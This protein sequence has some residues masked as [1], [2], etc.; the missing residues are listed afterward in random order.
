MQD[1][2]LHSQS[3]LTPN[4][5]LNT[6]IYK[7]T[8]RLSPVVYWSVKHCDNKK[9]YR[10]YALV[11]HKLFKM[12]IQCS[13]EDLEKYTQKINIYMQKPNDVRAGFPLCEISIGQQQ[14]ASPTTSIGRN[15]IHRNLYL[16]LHA[17]ELSPWMMKREFVQ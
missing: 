13:V 10:C 8:C 2:L 16:K 14:F 15:I 17:N 3:I 9:A 7:F 5:S 11:A 12:I 6:F 1:N 4:D